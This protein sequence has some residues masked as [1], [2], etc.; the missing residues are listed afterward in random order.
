MDVAERISEVRAAVRSARGRGQTVG[1]APTMGALHAGHVSLM[2]ASHRECGYT[3]V[4]IFVNPTQFGP[5]EDF[6]R[7]PRPRDADLAMC[8]RAGADLVFYPSVEEMYPPG[9]TTFVEVGGLSGMWEGAIRPGHF[10]G[11]AT[12]VAKLFQIVQCDRAYFGQKDY[13]QQL[14]LRRMVRDL[15]FPLEI[16]TCPIIRDGDGLA[17]SSRNAY[18]SAAERQ[19][20]LSIPAALKDVKQAIAAGEHAPRKLQLMMQQRLTNT[21]GLTLE[22]AIVVDAETMQE[23]ESPEKTMVALIAARVGTTRLIDNAIFS[24]SSESFTTRL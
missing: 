21:P 20:G 9:A 4:S 1:L 23:I 7:Y 2:E 11:V 8:E 6:Q 14:V 15:D 10:R 18:L 16:V 5:N 24:L 17:L 3:A 19:A 12:V 13:Q 22:Y